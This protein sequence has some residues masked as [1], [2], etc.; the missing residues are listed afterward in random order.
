MS[1]YVGDPLYVVC[2]FL[3]WRDIIQCSR[4]NKDFYSKCKVK[5][6]DTLRRL[7][8]RRP[9]VRDLPDVLLRGPILWHPIWDG[10]YW[11]W[12]PAF[13]QHKLV[14]RGP[15]VMFP[16]NLEQDWT[17]W[18]MALKRSLGV[19]GSTHW[20]KGK[21]RLMHRTERYRA[22][23][24]FRV[25]QNFLTFKIVRLKQVG[26]VLTKRPGGQPERRIYKRPRYDI[27]ATRTRG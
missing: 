23:V 15:E 17:L 27:C 3:R 10:P 14:E 25:R 4:V 2:T 8:R 9:D 12:T 11:V 22:L 1:T 5:D 6:K 19:R 7:A 24:A 21:R 16:I 26:R 13:Q 20:V 18:V